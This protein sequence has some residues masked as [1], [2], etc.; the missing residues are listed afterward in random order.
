M[1]FVWDEQKSRSNLAK[2]HVSF[3]FAAR[4]FDDPHIV[5]L[6]GD[7]AN[8][9]RWLSFGLVDGILVLAVAHTTEEYGNEEIIRI[10]SARKA[11]P[12]EKGL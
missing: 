7:F 10:I 2:H 5:S 6:P 1:P 4:V 12:R 3:A 9:E 11:T 8:E